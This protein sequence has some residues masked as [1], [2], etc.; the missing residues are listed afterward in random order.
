[1]T[2][3]S[4]VETNKETEIEISKLDEESKLNLGDWLSAAQN[5]FDDLQNNAE[6]QQ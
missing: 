5:I 2:N 6:S 3:N 4:R 1:M